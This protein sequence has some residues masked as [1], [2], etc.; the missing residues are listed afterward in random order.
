M[1]WQQILKAITPQNVDDFYEDLEDIFGI[2]GIQ[3]FFTYEIEKLFNELK[4]LYETDGVTSKESLQKF[5][6]LA[7]KILQELSN[8]Y[9][10]N[11]T[12]IERSGYSLDD[13]NELL[14][15]MSSKLMTADFIVDRSNPKVGG[16]G[17]AI[18]FYRGKDDST[19]VNLFK[20]QFRNEDSKKL[21]TGTLNHEFGHQASRNLNYPYRDEVPAGDTLTEEFIAYTSMYPHAPNL[22]KINTL[23]H[24]SVKAKA[25]VNKRTMKMYMAMK[26]A[27][28][29]D[30]PE[31]IDTHGDR[32]L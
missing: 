6:T 29:R 1:T 28:E 32:V 25:K 21:I 18:A 3:N 7:G 10:T 5:D 24:P 26:A 2:Y 19:N 22:A 8:L 31:L 13:F 9:N 20:P 14:N 4:T 30:A 15:Y 12:E 11:K 23:L 17:D 16:A 27:L